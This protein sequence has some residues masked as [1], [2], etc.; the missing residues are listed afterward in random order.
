[1]SQIST[2]ISIVV[3]ARDE[4]RLLNACI[5][6][7]E[8]ACLEAERFG[9]V[10]E[11]VLL[12]A[13]PSAAT[14]AWSDERLPARWL[15]T[16]VAES[17]IGTARNSIVP[18][19]RGAMIAFL[20]GGDLCSRDW[21]WRSY[22]NIDCNRTVMR[23]ELAILF[24]GSF[25]VI[26]NPNLCAREAD[27]ASVGMR[28]PFTTGI[29]ATKWLFATMPF[30]PKEIADGVESS[31]WHWTL[32]TLSKGDDPAIASGTWLYLRTSPAGSTGATATRIGRSALFELR[33]C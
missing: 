31:E 25:G 20:K 1:M 13:A 9:L 24:G 28:N 6:S 2:D 8:R 10:V 32:D 3:S 18:E 26:F 33:R 7:V 30:P 17:D 16:I 4:G 22:K 29:A 21:L 12:A 19:L 11:R 23:P 5:T 15:R 14:L 27:A